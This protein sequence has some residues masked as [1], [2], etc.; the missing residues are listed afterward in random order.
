MNNK[1]MVYLHNIIYLAVKENESSKKM[2]GTG[3]YTARKGSRFGQINSLF[4]FSSSVLAWD[5]K[6]KCL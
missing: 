2:E 3:K 1:T 5:S 6:L 4:A